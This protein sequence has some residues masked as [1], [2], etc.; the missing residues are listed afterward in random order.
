LTI[1]ASAGTGVVPRK[2]TDLTTTSASCGARYRWFDA[3]DEVR[4]Q[5]VAEMAFNLG[6]ARFDGFRV[7]IAA[8]A[9]GDYH[10]AAVE[11]L[12]SCWAEPVKG[13]ALVLAQR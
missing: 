3:L 2:T 12:A 8:I 4:Q 13:R 1:V 6:I 7:A 5:F 9:A 11:V 10:G